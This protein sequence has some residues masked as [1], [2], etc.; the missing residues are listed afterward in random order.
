M[1]LSKCITFSPLMLYMVNSAEFLAS[2][3]KSRLIVVSGLNGLGKL[4]KCASDSMFWHHNYHT[5]SS[6]QSNKGN[7]PSTPYPS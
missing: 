2:A 1:R 7:L 5:K 4:V 6:V 3:V